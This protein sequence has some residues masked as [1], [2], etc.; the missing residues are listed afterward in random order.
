MPRPVSL[1]AA[2]TPVE[3]ED[4]LPEPLFTEIR[5]VAV[6]F[7]RFDPETSG[8]ADFYRTL[9]EVDPEVLLACWKTP[10]LPPVLPPRLR[11]VCY[12]AGS[13]KR[14]ITRD[15]IER[16]LLVTNWGSSVGRLV[17][18]AALLHIL[19]CLRR[20]S[21]WTVAM[22]RENGW[23]TGVN[24]R[25]VSLFGRR[26]GLHGFGS[27]ARE[28]VRLLRPFGVMISA[29]AP[30]IDEA[31]EHEFGITRARSFEALFADNDIIVELAPLIPATKCCVT[32]HHLRLIRPGGVFVN[33]GRGKVVEE[34]ALV[35]VASEGKIFFGLDVFPIEPL[36]PN[37]PLRGL[38]NVM[39]TPHLAGPTVDRRCDAGAVALRN[40]SAYAE[41]KPLEALV[42]PEIYDYSS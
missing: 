2:L 6:H 35:R 13:V 9:T 28:L 33:V 19:S 41:G 4:F 42:T 17:A 3:Q 7:S 40:L 32:E 8:E 5:A 34:D 22:H 38:T 25:T 36:P 27:V 11:Y 23:R 10:R 16:G 29:F 39:L 31:A 15:Q 26:V 30:D 18:E 24:T 21:F 1:L 37:H 14:L 20:A 12:L